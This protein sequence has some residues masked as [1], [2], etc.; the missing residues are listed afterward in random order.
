MVVRDD[1]VLVRVETVDDQVH[2]GSHDRPDDVY[3]QPNA[4]PYAVNNGDVGGA[5]VEHVLSSSATTH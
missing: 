3:I 5:E 2:V 4:V 1:P